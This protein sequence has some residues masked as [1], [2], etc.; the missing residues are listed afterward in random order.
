[1]IVTFLIGRT[2]RAIIQSFENDNAARQLHTMSDAQLADIGIS[3]DQI[4]AVVY[5]TG[6]ER[7]NAHVAGVRHTAPLG[8]RALRA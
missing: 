1:M 3:R 4:D 7:A 5:G 6:S 8:G 2:W